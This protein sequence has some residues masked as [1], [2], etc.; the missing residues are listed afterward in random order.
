MKTQ[1]A[2][3]N[4]LLVR[5]D[6][7]CVGE[8]SCPFHADGRGSVLQVSALHFIHQNPSSVPQAFSRAVDSADSSGTNTTAEDVRFFV[9]MLYFIGTPNMSGLT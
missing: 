9:S 2:A 7:Y 5:A 3:V 4:R 6:T 8:P 1:F